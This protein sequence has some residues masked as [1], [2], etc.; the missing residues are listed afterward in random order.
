LIVTR[1]FGAVSV[2]GNDDEAAW[3]VPVGVAWLADESLAEAQPASAAV[4]AALAARRARGA[5]PV[6]A[7]GYIM[8]LPPE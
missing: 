6:R 2:T 5:R 4:A 7:R 1:P 3:G 8:L